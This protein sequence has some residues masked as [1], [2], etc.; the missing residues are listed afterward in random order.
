MDVLLPVSPVRRTLA[1]PDT[2]TDRF[3]RGHTTLRVSVTDRCNLRCVYCRPAADEPYGAPSEL[4]SFDEIAVLVG[5]LAARGTRSVRLTGGE[6]LVRRGLPALVRLLVRIPGIEFV[7][8]TSNGVLLEP[9][10]DAFVDAG[11]HGVNLSL[12][13]FDR[14][15]FRSL[16][17]LD[18]HD[19]VLRALDALLARPALVRKV[20][21][22]VQR[23]VNDDE[24]ARFAG[25]ARD[26]AID[27]RFLEYLP[28]AGNGWR[29]DRWI[30]A[31]EMI[32]RL[33][34][35]LHAL[36]PDG[37]VARLYTARGLRGRIGFV[38]G[39]SHK[40]CES[41]S[42]LRLSAQGEL[43][44]CLYGDRGVDLRTPLRSG[45]F[46]TALDA[47]LGAALDAKPRENRLRPDVAPAN[48]PVMTR[49]GG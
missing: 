23:G 30:A 11:L 3:G 27:V 31:S 29:P 9:A 28:F 34:V 19:A 40:F 1:R 39:I 22:V 37:G 33:G 26:H 24:L 12:D 35:D 10:L 47:L 41:C 5:E 42:R 49:V 36:P 32:A 4:L 46:E 17:G 45:G 18:A 13:T 14:E 44:S 20:N 2:L 48:A 15:R 16:C 38:S 21:V 43:R 7:G 6:P 25:L 8:I